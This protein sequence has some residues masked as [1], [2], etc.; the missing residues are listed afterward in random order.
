[1]HREWLLI[2]LRT[3]WTVGGTTYPAGSLLAADYDEFLAG[4]ARIEGGV[5][6]R[7]AHLLTTTRGP[8]TACC[9]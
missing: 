2:E 8:A 6:A 5:R 3:D 1:M 7:R 9:W 4:T